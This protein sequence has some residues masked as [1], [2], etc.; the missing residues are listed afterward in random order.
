MPYLPNLLK[1]NPSLS[2]NWE[3]QQQNLG[4]YYALDY[5]DMI[6]QLRTLD[7]VPEI[8]VMVPPPLY[9]PYPWEMNRT[10]INDIFP[11]LIRDIAS[12]MR[13]EVIDVHSRFIAYNELRPEIPLVCDGC[14]PTTQGVVIIADTV[15][16]AIL[17]GYT[18]VQANG[19]KILPSEKE[20]PTVVTR[21]AAKK[22]KN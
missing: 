13:V 16:D 5:V 7:P 15:R 9:D 22:T 20:K 2:F 18:A 14:H 21:K 12:V 4:D 17:A 11:K 10:I 1:Q 3:G 8:F 19:A 6:M